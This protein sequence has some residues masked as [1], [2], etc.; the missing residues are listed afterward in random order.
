MK[1]TCA[2]PCVGDMLRVKI[3]EI[4]HY[5]VCVGEDE[6]IQFGLPP[7]S[8]QGVPESSVC[9]CKTDKAAFACGG[10]IER[11]ELDALERLQRN[12]PQKTAELA[13][14][15]LGET[16]YNILHNNCEHFAYEC[17]LGKRVCTQ[18]DE[19]RKLFRS[20]P[21]VDVYV[22]VL[23]QTEENVLLF[24]PQREGEI[25]ACKNERVRREKHYVWKLLA[26]ALQRSFGLKMQDVSFEK[27]KSGKWTAKEC[28]FSL[29]HGGGVL[30]VVCSRKDVGIDVE[31]VDAL[32]A[33]TIE[34][35]LTDNE[36][37]ALSCVADE[38]KAFALT[39]LWT[40]KESLFKKQG[41]GAFKPKAVETQG[42]SF[43]CKHLDGGVVLCVATDTPEKVRFYHDCPVIG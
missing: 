39:E 3:G 17:V 29:S 42:E 30:A 27:D 8:R 18:A 41:G 34:K 11:A 31:R 16:G 7:V 28:S 37:A 10:A 6:I 25:A 22:A 2:E 9:V 32:R 12:P 35:A 13:R 20:L 36:R 24:P 5:G 40:K 19:V 21:I 23:P 14:A 4:Y 26:Y 1:W 33:T 15:R 38:E 43:Y